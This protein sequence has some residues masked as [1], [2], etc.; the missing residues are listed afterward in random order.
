MKKFY[1]TAGIALAMM[2]S[3][4]YASAETFIDDVCTYEIT[5][6]TTCTLTAVE[7]EG[8]D[9]V[10]TLD[11]PST[12]THNGTTYTV[13][14][15]GNS[16]CRGK[17]ALLEV[18]IP[19]TVT[20]IGSYAFYGDIA[21]K[22][23][24]IG[25]GVTSI[26][27]QAFD[28]CNAITKITVYA[29]EAPVTAQGTVF[30]ATT[31]NNAVLYIPAGSEESYEF[32][33]YAW[34]DFKHIRTIGDEEPENPNPDDPPVV[35]PETGLKMTAI[36]PVSGKTVHSLNVIL[37]AFELPKAEEEDYIISSMQN[38]ASSITLTGPNNL[39]I[40]PT[41]VR[42]VEN[43]P[44]NTVAITFPYQ[45]ADGEYTLTIP[46][47]VIA[48]MKHN[49]A[50]PG[51]YTP[52]EG[53][54]NNEITA[55]Y[56][57]ASS[58]PSIFDSYIL[59]PASGKTVASIYQVDLTF[60]KAP[61]AL[62]INERLP[63]V[64]TN[65]TDSYTGMI[66]G[67]GNER[68]LN[69]QSETERYVTIK[70]KG[71]WTLTIPAGVF[72]ASGESN[73]EIV[74]TYTISDDFDFEYTCQPLNLEKEELPDGVGA[75][76]IDFTF[77]DASSL[78]F[79]SI[80]E[81]V[82]ETFIVKYGDTVLPRVNN[83][84]SRQG[85]QTRINEGESILHLLISGSVFT[86]P[87]IFTVEAVKGAFTVDGIPSPAINY[88]VNY[89]VNKTYNYT[90]T[91]APGTKSDNLSR[92]TVAFTDAT[93]AQFIPDEAFV[94]LFQLPD[95]FTQYTWTEVEDAECPTFEFVFD[96]APTVYQEY[97]FTID[98][99]SF[100][101]DKYFFNPIVTGKY[102]LVD[103]E[104]LKTGIEEVAADSA[105]ADVYALDGRLVL[106]NATRAEM[107]QLAPG[108]YIAGG[109]KICVKN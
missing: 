87:A 66:N 73:A 95:P 31:K 83:V 3:A 8:L 34:V 13:T 52:V 88:A 28:A 97:S 63:I 94:V 26:Q 33:F 90:I 98:A 37:V 77:N 4:N 53:A 71:T 93:E 12:V 50:N 76:T 109:K 21:L 85:Y 61:Y 18:T 19:E 84:Y 62:N 41:S 17:E 106:P 57:V 48:K 46:A 51:Q 36:S 67:W 16:A 69:F 43:F 68:K 9:T 59:A 105:T 72:S 45:S 49:P 99:R 35:E 100:I 102:T 82:S 40:H 65:G 6:E 108:I 74:A 75:V 23:V 78:S 104:D 60:D 81:D 89:G 2:L 24:T 38:A 10:E 80:L 55:T 107:Q 58:I 14:A 92:F 103:P 25:A 79:P 5:S 86:E 20:T 54:T 22:T 11:I 1:S 47:G 91:P 70:D 27:T 29:I 96:P 56:T 7:S 101:L 15:I 39:S 30:T 42:P 32:D 64:L 44:V